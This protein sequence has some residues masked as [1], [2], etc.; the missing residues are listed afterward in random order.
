MKVASTRIFV[1]KRLNGTKDFRV[2]DGVGDASRRAERAC[3]DHA[4][5][6]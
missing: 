1:G 5:S 3:D 2:G 4:G 6:A